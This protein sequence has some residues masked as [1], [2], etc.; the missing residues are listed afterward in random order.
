MGCGDR[1]CA[2]S[3]LRTGETP[4]LCGGVLAPSYLHT[5]T[6]S[7]RLLVRAERCPGPPAGQWLQCPDEGGLNPAKN[8]IS[9]VKVLM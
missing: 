8:H 1:K 5:R 9:V 4:A 7:A 2:F 6:L 3:A